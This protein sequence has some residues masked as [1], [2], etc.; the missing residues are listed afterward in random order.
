MSNK[1]QGFIRRDNKYIFVKNKNVYNVNKAKYS[2]N[3]MVT[4]KNHICVKRPFTFC[5]GGGGGPKQSLLLFATIRKTL[6]LAQRED[7]CKPRFAQGGVFRLRYQHPANEVSLA[8]SGAS[9]D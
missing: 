9:V 2:F 5:G 3:K 1:I 8:P 4:R 6:H 7:G